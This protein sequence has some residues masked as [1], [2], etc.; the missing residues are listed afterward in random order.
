MAC[1]S[2]LVGSWFMLPVYVSTTLRFNF[3]LPVVFVLCA[4]S[5]CAVLYAYELFVLHYACRLLEAL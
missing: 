4:V 3:V 2:Q 1:T 5:C